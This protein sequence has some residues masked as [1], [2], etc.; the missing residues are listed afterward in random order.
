MLQAI[1]SR[2]PLPQ[3]L[4]LLNLE[5]MRPQAEIQHPLSCCTSPDHLYTL[6]NLDGRQLEIMVQE[7][8][9]Y[10]DG[11]LHKIYPWNH[12]CLVRAV[13][14]QAE[15]TLLH[16]SI[17]KGDNYFVVTFCDQP[18]LLPLQQQC[19]EM[20]EIKIAPQYLCLMNLKKVYPQLQMPLLMETVHLAEAQMVI[21]FRI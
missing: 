12:D 5:L 13:L 2:P 6:A 1:P 11:S 10:P 21:P 3:L 9:R 14:S 4:L 18:Y 16:L 15:T 7:L 8:V 19:K 20:R 17:I